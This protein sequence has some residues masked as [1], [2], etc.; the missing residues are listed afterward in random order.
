MSRIP[1][2]L[3]LG[4]VLLLAAATL[5]AVAGRHDGGASAPPVPGNRIRVAGSSTM[6]PLLRAIAARFRT[7]HPEVEVVVDAGGSGA[8]LALARA[9]RIDIGMV[10]RD[11][12]A[13]GDLYAIPIARDGVA[14]VVGRNNPVSSLDASVLRGLFTGKIT[15]WKTVGGRDRPVHV[16]V[17]QADR[18]SSALLT[19]YLGVTYSDLQPTRVFGDNEERTATVMQDP[20][21][22][23]VVSIAEAERRAREDAPI[24]LLAVDEVG[25]SSDNV[26]AGRYPMSRP[27]ML[28]SKPLP[29][30]LTK[31]FIRYALSADVADLVDQHGFVRYLD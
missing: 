17:G 12:R 8:G 25:A 19:D 29:A 27:L 26:R 3:R 23:V 31:D 11:I 13:A 16:F 22:L 2:L 14:I 6:A 15:D 18:G 20:D 30:G 5:S 24:K 10:S 28:V 1:S 7:L 21:A 9:G 4:L